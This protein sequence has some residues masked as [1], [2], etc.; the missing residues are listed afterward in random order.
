MIEKINNIKKREKAMQ[1]KTLN[2][3]ISINGIGVHSGAECRIKIHPAIDHCGIIYKKTPYRTDSEATN[4]IESKYSNVSQTTMCTTLSNKYGNS[5]SVVEHISAAFYALDI[6]NAIIEVEGEEI[7]LLD[8]SSKLFI[9]AILKVG[10]KEQEAKRKTL[11]ILKTIKVGD[12]S[13]YAIL[14]PSNSFTINLKCEFSS[15]GLI[16]EPFSFDFSKDNF[17]KEISSARTFGF[18]ADVEF[19]RKDNLA[20]GASLEN[21]LVL[22]NQ[23]K[24]MNKDG[25]RYVNEP[26]R[27]KILD[28]IGDLSLAQYKIIGQYDGFCSGHKINNILL[29]ELFKDRS[30]FEIL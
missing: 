15:K 17:I 1:Q 30:N 11:K 22:D 24:P 28:I 12:N 9:E 20:L 29:L 7:P 23:G 16:T 3:P 8:G 2:A 18:F 14:S 21:T 25:F 13:C 5:I 6:S 27:H 10:I 19:L 4:T 26:I